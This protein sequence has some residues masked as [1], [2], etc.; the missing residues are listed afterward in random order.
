[1]WITLCITCG[2]HLCILCDKLFSVRNIRVRKN[3]D[4]RTKMN[5]ENLTG[6]EIAQFIREINRLIQRRL[7]TAF[8]ESGLTPPQLM[9]LHYLF[10][11]DSRNVSDISGHLRLAASTVSSILDRLERNGFVFRERDKTDKRIVK[12]MLTPKANEIKDT[13]KADL[14]T[15]MN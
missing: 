13:L 14:H 12:I 4:R 8:Q 11:H 5:A 3:L 10:Q 1:M 9:V 7:R 6:R 2:L 15:F